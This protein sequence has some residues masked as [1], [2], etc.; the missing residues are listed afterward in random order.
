MKDA[1]AAI[2]DTGLAVSSDVTQGSASSP[3]GRKVLVI[4]LPFPSIVQPT[5]GVFVK[6]R[7]RAIAQL[8]GYEVRVVAPVPYFPPIRQ[9]PR[10]YQWSQFPREEMVDGLSVVRPRYPLPPKIGGYFHPALMYPAVRRAVDRMR[11]EFDFDVIDAHFAYPAGVVASMLS[12]RYDRPFVITGRGEDMLRFPNMPFK[13]PRIRKALQSAAGCI[14]VSGE[15]AAAMKKHGAAEDRL[16]VISN[17]VDCQRFQPRDQMQSRTALGLPTDRSI[18]LTVG[19]RLELKGFHLLI[20]AIPQI[21]QQFPNVLAVIVGGSPRS[22]TDMTPILERK[23]QE[24]GLEDHVLL[25]GRVEHSSLPTWYSAVDVFTLLSS[26]EGSP[27]VLLEALACGTPAVGTPVGAIPDMLSDP[28]TG[29]V[30]GDRNVSSIAACLV[31][32]LERPWDHSRIRQLMEKQ[33]W[34][35]TAERCAAV[36]EAALKR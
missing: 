9:F 34:R 8:P 2:A 13:G 28:A 11:R 7:V 32:A 33:T 19:D 15:I 17:G 1:V 5:Y 25:A 6:E 14:G 26:R 35:A 31:D 3:T 12:E 30:L 23:I 21:R 18:I 4:S 20:D 36:F 10:W 22:G 24:Q 27:N 16:Q 29:I